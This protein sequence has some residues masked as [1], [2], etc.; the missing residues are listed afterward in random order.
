MYLC[1]LS[2]LLRVLSPEQAGNAK[3]QVQFNN[4]DCPEKGASNPMSQP[5]SV[6]KYPT[7]SGLNLK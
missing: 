7:N 5:E 2:F 1:V 4:T 3:C 6:D